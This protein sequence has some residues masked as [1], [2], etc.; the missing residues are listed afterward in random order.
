MSDEK[1]KWIDD[2]EL[3]DIAV[4]WN[5]S[6]FD[7]RADMYNE[8]GQHNFVVL[9]PEDIAQ[10]MAADGWNV[11]EKPAY[12]EGDPPEWHLEVKI[13]YKFEDPMIWLIKDNGVRKRR[14]R[15]KQS[16]L[17]DIKRSTTQK[18]DVILTPS[19]WTQPGRSGIT[20]YAKE[21]YA[22]IKESR[23]AAQYDEYEDISVSPSREH[24]T[25][26]EA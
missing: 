26:S 2:V 20:A 15:A 25:A 17:K 24:D 8:E 23:F 7:G 21:L 13:S 5:F 10:Q 22:T 11:K 3:A 6:H 12:E 19:K 14:V 1:S 16:D 4:K 9:L 18:I